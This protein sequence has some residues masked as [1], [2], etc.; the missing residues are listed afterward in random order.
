MVL[1]KP[2]TLKVKLV[3]IGLFFAAISI[4]GCES[5]QESNGKDIVA[6]YF[7]A[8]FA[9][10]YVSLDSLLA[11]DFVFIGPK[12]SDTLDKPALIRSW[13]STHQRNDSLQMHNPRIYDVTGQGTLD[14]EASLILHY[15]DA[16]FHN[17]DFGVWVEFPVHVQFRVL[18]GK[19][20]WAQIIMN[21]SDV[22]SQLGYRTV[23]PDT[24]KDN[25]E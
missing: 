16:R 1:R 25:R 14:Q 11:E 22:Q 4:I 6:N 21:Q 9:E 15:Y 2:S 24:V 23:L 5:A 8:A 19:I 7:T 20:Q 18:A 10:D 13:K 17:A 12:I 3:C